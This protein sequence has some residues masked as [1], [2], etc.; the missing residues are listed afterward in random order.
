M[1]CHVESSEISES[2]HPQPLS[3]WERARV[4]AGSLSHWE[5]ARVR[6]GSLAPR[7]RGEGEGL[8]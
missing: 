2:P 1:G 8:L 7:E 4:R 5:R 3:H 6:A